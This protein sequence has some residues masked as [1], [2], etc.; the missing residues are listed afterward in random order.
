MYIY[1]SVSNCNIWLDKTN[2]FFQCGYDGKYFNSVTESGSDI[3]VGDTR[4]YVNIVEPKPKRRGRPPKS[5]TCANTNRKSGT[6][7]NTSTRNLL[8]LSNIQLGP[9]SESEERRLQHNQNEKARRNNI[10]NLFLQLCDICEP[11][12]LPKRAKKKGEEEEEE[13]WEEEKMKKEYKRIHTKQSTLNAARETILF[14]Q[15]IKKNLE[16]RKEETIR[17][18]LLSTRDLQKVKESQLYNQN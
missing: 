2:C 12:Y 5:A 9:L 3:D 10:T 14:Y 8:N 18:N 15:E 1:L 16:A 6:K 13:E 7:R 11:Q 4:C 17:R